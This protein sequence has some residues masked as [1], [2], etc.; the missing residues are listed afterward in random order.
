MIIP[1]ICENKTCSKP[2][3]STLE[4]SVIFFWCVH[5]SVVLWNLDCASVP[6]SAQAD[7]QQQLAVKVPSGDQ[8]SQWKAGSHI[9]IKWIQIGNIGDIHDLSWY[10]NKVIELQSKERLISLRATTRLNVALT[11]LDDFRPSTWISPRSA[12]ALQGQKI[13]ASGRCGSSW[14]WLVLPFVGGSARWSIYY[15]ITMGKP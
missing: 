2:P 1:N 11:S 7:P 5:L 15:R 10:P 13:V 6:S 4:G 9:C 3:T 12:H 14:D 8:T